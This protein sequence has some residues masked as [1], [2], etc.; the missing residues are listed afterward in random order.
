[1]GRPHV[2]LMSLER[3]LASRTQKR[4]KQGSPDPSPQ[5][6]SRQGSSLAPQILKQQLS[7]SLGSPVGQLSPQF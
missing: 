3:F 7:P 6:Q 1:M 2:H 5:G 4:T